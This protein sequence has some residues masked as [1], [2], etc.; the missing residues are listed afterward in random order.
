MSEKIYPIKKIKDD[1]ITE[2]DYYFTQSAMILGLLADEAVSISNYNRSVQTDHTIKFLD[3]IGVKTDKKEDCIIV[4]PIGRFDSLDDVSLE[5][6]GDIFTLGLLIGYIAGNKESC[7]LR[8][9]DSVNPDLVDSLVDLLNS[10]GIDIYNEADSNIIVFRSR[11]DYPVEIK[12]N[13][14]LS[15]HKNCLMMY[16]L[17]SGCSI[18]IREM[19]NTSN[20]F[21]AVL[22]RLCDGL[23]SR[24]TK[25]IVEVDL[26]DPRKKIR[27]PE[28]EYKRELFIR[29]NSKVKALEL[30]APADL[31]STLAA[32]TLASMKMQDYSLKKVS[33]NRVSSKF[34]TFLKGSGVELS[35]SDKTEVENDT[36][37]TISLKCKNIKSKKFSGEQTGLLIDEIPFIC[38]M[39]IL[40]DGTTIIRGIEEYKEL[41]VDPFDEIAQGLSKLGVKCGVL[42]DGFAI[43]GIREINGV[44]FPAF[45]NHKIALAFAIA[46]AAGQGHSVF[47]NFDLLTDNYPDFVQFITS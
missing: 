14:N 27:R 31:V 4:N 25:M 45:Q 9:S 34:L 12:I 37:A 30:T 17:T 46:A 39:S 3:S 41:G 15:V 44:D 18:R 16:S 36:F 11:T 1:T 22:A 29:P 7:V 32:L 19:A 21:E 40:G 43:E 6:N 20:H 47:E 24:D 42:K 35:I 38:A 5:Y 2:G 28:A 13:S 23:E 33:I 26:I 8:Y 10:K